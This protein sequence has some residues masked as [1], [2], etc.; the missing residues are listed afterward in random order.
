[1]E[2]KLL[3]LRDCGDFCIKR[4]KG[5]MQKI[6]IAGAPVETPFSRGLAINRKDCGRQVEKI[7]L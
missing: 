4:T 7:P 6:V 5:S 2:R 3:I 1:M